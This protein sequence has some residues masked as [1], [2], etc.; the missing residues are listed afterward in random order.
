MAGLMLRRF[1]APLAA[2][3][4]TLAV[5]VGFW[6]LRSPEATRIKAGDMAP[7]L[8][9]QAL[10]GE[11]AVTLSDYRGRPVLLV[12]FLSDCKICDFEA[13]E[14]ERLNREFLRRGLLVV[15]IGVD[16]ERAKLREFVRRHEITFIVLEDPNGAGVKQ[17]FGSWKFPETYLLDASGRVD[18]VYLG[19]VNWR[20]PDLR[21][22]I[23]R[24]LPAKLR[25]VP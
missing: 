10:G 22:R 6:W 19:S 16:A 7:E 8:T 25:D 5:V 15:G 18:A 2:T 3:A 21:E 17:A 9:L 13:P 1:A 23:R 20:S 4:V 24:L 14:I 12:M 11:S